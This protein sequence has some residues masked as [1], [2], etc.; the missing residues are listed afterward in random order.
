MPQPFEPRGGESHGKIPL[1]APRDAE[2]EP[3]ELNRNSM[4]REL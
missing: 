3:R 2:H 4:V 1:G